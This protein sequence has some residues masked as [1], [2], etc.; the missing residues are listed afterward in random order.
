LRSIKNI[1][2]SIF[3]DPAQ[4][5]AGDFTFIAKQGQFGTRFVGRVNDGLIM[6]HTVLIVFICFPIII[7]TAIMA[8]IYNNNNDNNSNDD[9]KFNNDN[10]NNG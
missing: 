3:R 10:K 4:R 8:I 7:V 5:G 6:A 1:T 9:N 2:G